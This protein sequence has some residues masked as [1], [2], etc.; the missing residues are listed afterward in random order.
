MDDPNY[1]KDLF[2]PMK[3]LARE[4]P[5][6][7]ARGG[8]IQK[9]RIGD[10]LQHSTEIDAI[11]DLAV[12]NN[13]IEHLAHEQAVRLSS[14]DQLE[15]A[16]VAPRNSTDFS[17]I[18][19]FTIPE[20]SRMQNIRATSFIVNEQSV[21]ESSFVDNRT[22]SLIDSS[23]ESTQSVQLDTPPSMPLPTSEPPPPVELPRQ[24]RRP[25]PPSIALKRAGTYNN[26]HQ[27][28]R[29]P[30]NRQVLA[31]ASTS[32][33]STEQNGCL[34]YSNRPVNQTPYNTTT[35][36]FATPLSENEEETS[37]ASRRPYSTPSLS[38]EPVQHSRS[39]IPRPP[40]PVQLQSIHN[41]PAD[42]LDNSGSSTPQNRMPTSSTRRQPPSARKLKSSNRTSGTI[43]SFSYIS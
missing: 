19:Q 1:S 13:E 22:I 20:Q 16:A 35:S 4:M 18:V 3:Y 23:L 39:P 5:S 24:I 21:E 12:N 14:S 37:L 38:Q 25:P 26:N 31:R 41:D 32:Q 33:T 42:Q 34:S 10:T 40:M 30:N 7:R 11:T 2:E 29:L 15:N 28:S 43:D 17:S 8:G 27:T 9:E 36:Y 6:A